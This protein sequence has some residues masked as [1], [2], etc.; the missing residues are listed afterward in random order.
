MHTRSK[1]MTEPSQQQRQ[2]AQ[3][4]TALLTQPRMV[5]EDNRPQTLQL[6]ALQMMVGSS[7]K[8]QKQHKVLTMIRA[9]TDS[10]KLLSSQGEGAVMQRHIMPPVQR[11]P[12][13][14]EQRDAIYYFEDIEQDQFESRK[15]DIQDL[16]AL[17]RNNGW[18]D[19]EERITYALSDISE[20]GKIF[21]NEQELE[22]RWNQIDQTDPANLDLAL[23]LLE[24]A[25]QYQLDELE[26]K[27]IR[28]VRRTEDERD[29]IL[30]ESSI[31]PEQQRMLN[32]YRDES[33]V[34]YPELVYLVKVKGSSPIELDF[35]DACL[36]QML[37]IGT[38]KVLSIQTYNLL[39]PYADLLT[40]D[41]AA[42][43]RMLTLA[44]QAAADVEDYVAL[45]NVL[46]LF[47]EFNFMPDQAI[48]CS[49]QA[50]ADADTLQETLQENVRKQ[51]EV[52]I[53]EVK[54]N[55][56]Q[57]VVKGLNRKEKKDYDK[58]F[59]R[60]IEKAKGKAEQNAMPEVEQ[61]HHSTLDKFR[62]IQIISRP[63]EYERKKQLYH[64]FCQGYHFHSACT[65]ALE[66]TAYNTVRAAECMDV[67]VSQPNLSALIGADG[68]SWQ[69]YNNILSTIGAPA[70][71]AILAN[72]SP[73]Q[74]LAFRLHPT[75]ML[76]LT[77]CYATIPLQHLAT[78]ASAP[79]TYAP[80]CCPGAETDFAALITVYTPQQLLQLWQCMPTSVSGAAA[81]ALLN[82]Y[83]TIAATAADLL[84]CLQLATQLNLDATRLTSIISVLAP[85]QTTVQF[86]AALYANAL[87]Q[88]DRDSD[89]N[90]WIACLGGLIVAPATTW[91]IAE[92]ASYQLSY[93]IGTEKETWERTVTVSNGGV[94][95][96]KFKI[97]YHPFADSATVGSPY[98]S[99]RHLKPTRGGDIRMHWSSIPVS[100]RSNI[101]NR[102]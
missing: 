101:S 62:Q 25:Q 46:G 92:S 76:A 22:Q 86:Q 67:V 71:H 23:E 53:A 94:V 6:K 59:N 70:A 18:D 21:S 43:H 29:D 96:N 69:I 32:K 64:D 95:Y 37:A 91:S 9:S 31:S 45:K 56:L 54:S 83:R 17:S 42:L 87:G 63:Q 98:A 40:P 97:H 55:N 66:L 58:N 26:D 7:A 100:I 84:A 33:G 82:Q 28:Y 88:Y 27:I 80:I 30:S 75:A 51:A 15:K 47:A 3:Q 38:T 13:F 73:E 81:T 2:V 85:G 41:S 44:Q 5:F 24:L 78:W 11:L 77:S 89:F 65:D 93:G 35:I 19:L 20:R 57:A 36:Q 34:D 16:L 4:P 8:Q 14:K 90:G 60:A 49:L 10:Q 52:L 12:R 50:M 72:V 1:A 102:E 48:L 74:L 68:I 79:S 99:R 39:E 61:I